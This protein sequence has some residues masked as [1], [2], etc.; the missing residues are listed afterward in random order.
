MTS[1]TLVCGE[2]KPFLKEIGTGEGLAMQYGIPDRWWQMGSDGRTRHKIRAEERR[3]YRCPALSEKHPG[4]C[5]GC[6]DR[7]QHALAMASDAGVPGG[8]S[9]GSARGFWSSDRAAAAGIG[10]GC[11]DTLKDHGG[12]ELASINSCQ[13]RG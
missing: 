13:S 8:L 2:C 10:S 11:I 1:I 5:S 12:P 6:R 9:N 3:G 4:R 7:Y